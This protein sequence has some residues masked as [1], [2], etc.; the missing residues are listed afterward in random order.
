MQELEDYCYQFLIT[1]VNVEGLNKGTDLE[2]FKTLVGKTKNDVMVAGGITTMEEIRYIHQLGFNQV[3]G[4]AITSGKLD[5][6]DCYIEIMDFE[7][8]NGLIPTIVQDIDSKEVL[9][10]AYSSKESLR[11]TYNIRKATYYSRSREILWTK[12]EKSGNIQEI[13]KI[14]LD[15]DSDTILFLVK[16]IGNACHRNKKNCFLI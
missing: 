10:L 4:M 7:K 9:M 8:Q 5:I 2:F 16:Q 11:K 1:N 14:Y 15:C 12:G 13:E 6:M 3:L